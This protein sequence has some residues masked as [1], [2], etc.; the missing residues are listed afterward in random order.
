M[1]LG[2]CIVVRSAGWPV[3]AIDALADAALAAEVD[4]IDDLATRIA[5][6]CTA[7]GVAIHDTVPRT[8]EPSLRRWLLDVR[9]TVRAGD[10]PWRAAPQGVALPPDAH[11]LFALLQRQ[12]ADRIEL[13]ARR[14]ALALRYKASLDEQ[15]MSVRRTAADERFC[16]ALAIS[17]PTLAGRWLGRR[18]A[19]LAGGPSSRTLRQLDGV[20]VRQLARAVG[21]TTPH[22]AWSTST[23]AQVGAGDGANGS[24]VDVR[25]EAPH[26]RAEPDLRPFAQ[27]IDLLWRSPA[28]WRQLPLRADRAARLHAQVWSGASGAVAATAV[29]DLLMDNVRGGRELVVGD[30]LKV[31]AARGDVSRVT[32]A[33]ES[34]V[35]HLLKAGV[36]SPALALPPAAVDAWQA[37]AGAAAKLPQALAGPWQ[38]A[39]DT[40]RGVCSQVC[41]EGPDVHAAWLLEAQANL[42]NTMVALHQAAGLPPPQPISALVVHTVGALTLVLPAAVIGQLHAAAARVLDAHARSGIA[43]AFRAHRLGGLRGV[44]FPL[45][46]LVD[47]QSAFDGAALAAAQACASGPEPGPVDRAGEAGSMAFALAS[48]TGEPWFRWGRPHPDFAT[49]RI[50]GLLGME[51]L[52]PDIPREPE[53]EVVGIDPVHPNLAL[54]EAAGR[55]QIGRHAGSS[56]DLARSEVEID[57][58]GRGWL[59]PAEAEQR[60]RWRPVYSATAGIGVHDPVGRLLLRL[61]MSHGWEYLA[62]GF[63]MCAARGEANE[64]VPVPLHDD[65][66]QA[67][68]WRLPPA[69]VAALRRL[70]G[71]ELFIAWRRWVRSCGMGRWLWV[72]PADGGADSQSLIRTDSPLMIEGVLAPLLVDHDALLL[73][74]PPGDPQDW[75]LADDSGHY[76][77]EVVVTWHALAAP[78][79]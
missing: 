14:R 5:D 69:A 62:F 33:L 26:W 2:S 7:L 44:T 77:A 64:P 50:A 36:L 63:P 57:D 10:A 3:E 37:L 58:A 68:A 54:R 28:A 15:R 67:P 51:P 21:R 30:L 8:P 32:D 38:A 41:R 53:I 70:S 74:A 24:R 19:A 4:A 60:R 42:H 79:S 17:N 71:S 55:P 66:L 22:G 27:V 34:A 16:R 13:Q 40:A 25:A 1:K 52:P 59:V 48:A 23:S 35:A 45:L 49:W 12:H 47:G 18:V 20:L 61:A 29:V 72:G 75:P 31:L 76:L 73:T 46:A 9:R 65:T 78:T 56:I 11:A 43:E 6:D 39:V